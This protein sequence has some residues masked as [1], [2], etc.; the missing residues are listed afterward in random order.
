M[1]DNDCL[2]VES[3]LIWSF[4]LILANCFLN[5]LPKHKFVQLSSTDNQGVILKGQN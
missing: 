4:M 1:V 5:I 3:S 2:E